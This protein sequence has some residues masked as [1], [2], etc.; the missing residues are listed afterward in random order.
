M[1]LR[2]SRVGTVSFASTAQELIDAMNHETVLTQ[3]GCQNGIVSS[4]LGASGEVHQ[5]H[6]I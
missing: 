2:T 6:Q 4:R 3:Q 1:I 5:V